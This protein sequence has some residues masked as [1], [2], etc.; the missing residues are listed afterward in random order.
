LLR[1]DGYPQEK[2]VCGAKPGK[3]SVGWSY[4]TGSRVTCKRCL[5]RLNRMQEAS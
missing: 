3:R 1:D 5:A 4:R 2:A